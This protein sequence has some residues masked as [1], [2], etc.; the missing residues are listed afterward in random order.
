MRA[1]QETEPFPTCGIGGKVCMHCRT[2]VCAG[3]P[4][5]DKDDPRGREYGFRPVS[6]RTRGK[7]SAQCTCE[8]VP[9]RVSTEDG[10]SV[11]AAGISAKGPSTAGSGAVI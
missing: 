10:A 1:S 8:T 9:V 5:G 3:L 4:L 7:R 2:S 11:S 6:S